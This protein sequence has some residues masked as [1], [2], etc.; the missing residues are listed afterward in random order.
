MPT[1]NFAVLIMLVVLVI[2]YTSCY[3]D[4]VI[5][6]YKNDLFEYASHGKEY[7][8]KYTWA[9]SM[10]CTL[11]SATNKYLLNKLTSKAHE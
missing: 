4:S 6:S 10:I 2:I 9:S 7:Y 11:N 1:L 5:K 3:N 8:I